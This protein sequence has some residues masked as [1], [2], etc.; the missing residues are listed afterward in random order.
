MDNTLIYSETHALCLRLAL[1]A[2]DTRVDVLDN[3]NETPAL[4]TASSDLYGAAAWTSF[5]CTLI[6]ALLIVYRL[7]TIPRKERI[8]N[9]ILKNLLDTF[10]QSGALLVM[11]SLTFATIMTVSVSTFSSISQFVVISVAASFANSFFPIIFVCPLIFFLEILSEALWQ[12]IA[13]TIMVAQVMRPSP[14]TASNMTVN[15][16]DLEYQRTDGA[17][18]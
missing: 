16:A 9:R 6:T 13:P 5:A 14:Q 1:F 7:H 18:G 3:D 11:A 10:I 15:A 12:G 8:Y 2:A 17:L 4:D